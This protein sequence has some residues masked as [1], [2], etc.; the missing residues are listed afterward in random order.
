MWL[1][2]DSTLTQRLTYAVRKA[3]ERLLRPEQTFQQPPA[4]SGYCYLCGQGIYRNQETE[5]DHIIPKSRGGAN[6]AENYAIVHQWCNRYKGARLPSEYWNTRRFR[7]R[8]GQPPSWAQD[9]P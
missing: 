6:V 5:K 9:F 1:P 3:R 7:E 2:G 4:L 8:F